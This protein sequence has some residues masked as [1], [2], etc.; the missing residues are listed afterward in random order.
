MFCFYFQTLYLNELA[1]ET[2]FRRWCVLLVRNL[3]RIG[4][5]TYVYLTRFKLA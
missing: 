1:C 2:K 5:S 3:V 4:L